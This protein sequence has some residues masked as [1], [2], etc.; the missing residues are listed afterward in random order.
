MKIAFVCPDGHSIMLFCTGILKTLKDIADAEVYVLCAPGP[1]RKDIEA[2]GVTCVHVDCYRF[3]S[4]VRDCRYFLS[5]YRVFRREQ[6]DLVINFS[7]KPNI[8]GTPAAWLAGVKKV[9]VHVVGLGS[10]FSQAVNAKGR[11]VKQIFVR[12]YHLTFRLGTKVWFTNK[13]DLEYFLQRHMID[14]DKAVLT[15]NYLNIDKFS[16]GSV[17]AAELLELKQELRIAEGERVVV[18]V[19]RMIWPKG[20][21]EYAEAAELLKDRHPHIRFFLVAPLEIGSPDA[22]PESYIAEKEKT[23]NLKWLGFR[24]EVKKIYA[25]ADLAVLPS[26]YKEGGYPLGLLEPMA[27]GK[28][29]ITADC[30]DCRGAVEN[31]KNGLLVPAR[32]SKALAEAILTIVEDKTKADSYGQYSR[33]KI[34]TEF[35]EKKVIAQAF[36]DIGFVG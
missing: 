15:R 18:M 17:S 4:P 5:L 34:E 29:V 20:I 16:P 7:T 9:V 28:P 19:A 10:A 13:N 36:R 32:D 31:G 2:L 8:Y 25:L 22:V 12:L 30:I 11:I 1:Y 24:D 33:L 27:M 3:I 21:R 6:F 35:D 26:Y 14:R 23:A